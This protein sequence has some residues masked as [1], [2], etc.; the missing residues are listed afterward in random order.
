[1]SLIQKIVEAVREEGDVFNPTDSNQPICNLH[2]DIKGWQ[3]TYTDLDFREFLSNAYKLR[4]LGK[5]AGDFTLLLNGSLSQRFTEGLHKHNG[6]IDLYRVHNLNFP[7]NFEMRPFRFCG[8]PPIHSENGRIFG[9][10]HPDSLRELQPL[11]LTCS[12]FSKPHYTLEGLYTK[13]GEDI[14]K[15]IETLENELLVRKGYQ[16]QSIAENPKL[17]IKFLEKKY[18]EL[19]SNQ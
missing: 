11:K 16:I 12:P 17:K 2:I 15:R 8:L 6:E 14:D 1:M 3:R 19:V 5:F 10:I 4:V 7:D 18:R 9:N 13:T